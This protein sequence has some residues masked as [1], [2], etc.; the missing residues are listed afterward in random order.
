MILGAG[1]ASFLLPKGYE[2]SLFPLVLVL[3]LLQIQLA[4]A[5]VSMRRLT[6]YFLLEDRKDQVGELDHPGIEI[7]GGDFFWAEPPPK[8]AMPEV[9]KKKKGG[10]KDKK[11]AED[12]TTPAKAATP[13]GL[14]RE[15]DDLESGKVTPSS[16]DSD[17]KPDTADD[18]VALELPGMLPDEGAGLAKGMAWRM[19]GVDLTVGPGE[20]VCVVGRVGS[21]KSSLVQAI[22]GEMEVAGGTV[23]VGGSVAYAAQQ[24]WIINASVKDNVAFGKEFEEEKWEKCVGACCLA[25]DLE[26]LPAGADTEIGEKGINL[27]GGQKQRISLARALYQ[28]A[29]VY[30][31]DDPLSAVDVH[32]GRHIFERFI[33]G[34]IANKARL[35]VTNQLQYLPHADRI[36]VMDAG[37]IVAQGTYEECQSND[38]FARLLSDHNAQAPE[39]EGGQE[40]SIEQK[41]AKGAAFETK[42]DTSGVEKRMIA[43][44]VATIP[45]ALGRPGPA[46]MKLNRGETFAR[47]PGAGSL[48]A[49]GATTEG[50]GTG[51]DE[52]YGKKLQSLATMRLEAGKLAE[53]GEEEGDKPAK[54]A[55]MIKE[56][57]EVGQV[58][59]KVYWQYIKAYGVLSFL[60]LIVL[61]SSEQSVRILTNWYLSKWTGKVAT[62]QA[63]AYVTG[64]PFHLNSTSFIG[65]YLGLAFG[66]VLLTGIRSFTN[67]MS[68]LTA[69]RI[70]HLKSLGTLVRAPV[71][72]FDTTPVGRILNRFSK[73]SG[74]LCTCLPIYLSSHPCL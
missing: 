65:G 25:Q 18:S 32:V 23:A 68:A 64:Q 52:K 63:E 58:T 6:Q 1:C 28:D 8:L 36:V 46:D 24:A 4:N 9:G 37:R 60:S 30:I 14:K 3:L 59:G 74:C 57:Q 72:F 26:I 43:D 33:D 2:D 56:D 10:K 42:I 40:E 11:V 48:G 53:K 29:D 22:L 7:R 54:G 61:W 17:G 15:S 19:Q 38:V 45:G 20:L 39:A 44:T 5:L 35:L 66:F 51:K 41:P 55:L 62:Q 73:V 31:L 67:L 34:A 49:D 16:N 50:D 71:T 13:P 70:I 47:L 21:G 27:S 69:S 12:V